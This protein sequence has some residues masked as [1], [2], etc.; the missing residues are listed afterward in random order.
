MKRVND[1]VCKYYADV[2]L[3]KELLSNLIQEAIAQ[4]QF[5][6]LDAGCGRHGNWVRR[7]GPD[8]RVIGMDLGSDLT[9][10]VP[11]IS[12][13]LGNIPFRDESFSFVFS[14]SVF[15][16]L[17]KPDEVLK[18]FHR[19]LK[20]GGRCAI[21][22]PNRYDYSSIVA[23]LTPQAFHEFFVRRVYGETAA[24]D[25]Y[26][27]LYRANT[28]GYFRK[29]ASQKAGWKIVQ[30]LGLRHYP[31]NFAFSRILFRLG[32]YFDEFIAKMKWTAL[33]PSLLIVLEKRQS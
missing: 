29:V 10:D 30:L 25:T 24:Y 31:A 16:H 21:L 1:L 32:I 17:A 22:T 33:Q 4:K 19:I 27:V 12:G 11:V 7:F 20:P 14:R 3:G 13:D 9:S 2:T 23:A 15:E 26:P 18:E 5:P 8:A 28:P 6:I